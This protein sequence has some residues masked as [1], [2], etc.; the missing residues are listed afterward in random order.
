MYTMRPAEFA[1]RRPGSLDEALS[2]LGEGE[3]RGRWPAD[4]A[5]SR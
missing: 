4:T 3:R 2:L 5:C 1:Y